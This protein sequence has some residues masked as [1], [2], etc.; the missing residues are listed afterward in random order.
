MGTDKGLLKLHGKSLIQYSIDAI[1]PLC[2]EIVI[3]SNSAGY[4][5]CGYRI[6][7]DIY[8]GLGPIGGIHAGLYYSSTEKNIILS[9]D[10]P[11]V[12]TGLLEYL[13]QQ[14]K[15]SMATI[16]VH[17]N[18]KTEPLCGIYLKA[19]LPVIEEH[20]ENKDF[21]LMNVLFRASTQQVEILPGMNLYHPYLFLNINDRDMLKKA[22]KILL[23]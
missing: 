22:S 12:S 11:F 8:P 23:K 10:M 5:K 17:D 18:A 7:N 21:K 2:D 13:L 15:K 9:C 19:I 16:P 6:I 3:C 1:K 14:S 20:I 4:E